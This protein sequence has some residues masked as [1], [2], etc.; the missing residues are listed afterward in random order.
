[1]A[2]IPFVVRHLHES[3]L[4]PFADVIEDDEAA[5]QQNLYPE[6]VDF[7]DNDCDGTS[8]DLR[9]TIIND[10][11]GNGFPTSISFKAEGISDAFQKDISK[12]DMHV[13]DFGSWIRADEIPEFVD[14]FFSAVK[15]LMGTK[16]IRR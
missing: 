3:A 13:M 11:A 12:D 6:L 2:A 7:L 16:G 4:V 9:N 14:D 8:G 5:I 15:N 10:N 1:M